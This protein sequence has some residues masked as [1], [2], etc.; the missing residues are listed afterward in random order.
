MVHDEQQDKM[1]D[2]TSDIDDSILGIIILNLPNYAGGKDLWQVHQ[3]NL[4]KANGYKP[5]DP[6]DHHLEVVAYRSTSD[7][8]LTLLG[9]KPAKRIAQTRAVHFNIRELHPKE[10]NKAPDTYLQIDGE[11]MKLP[12][13][14]NENRKAHSR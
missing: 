3:N 13:P 2:I 9:L 6:S 11:P 12:V 5:Q 7:F 8:A 4:A 1:V 10:R 14:E